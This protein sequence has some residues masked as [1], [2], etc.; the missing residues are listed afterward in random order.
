MKKT[1]GFPISDKK[2][3]KRRALVAKDIEKINNKSLIYIE[4]GYGKALGITDQE[5]VDMGANVVERHIVMKQDIICDPKIG[6]AG[7]LEDLTT[8][9]MIFGWVHAVQNKDITD[10]LINLK[11]SAIAWEDMFEN[12]RH[13]FWRNNEIAGEAAV[14]H[15]YNLYGKLPY[16]TKVAI[17]GRG[18]IG[19][20]AYKT[21]VALGADV[22]MYDRKTERL[23]REE[24]AE[25]D[26][27]VNAILWDVNRKD[28]II[29]K[30]DL[31]HM[32]KGAMIIDISCD[33][34]KGIETSIPTTIDNPVY[35]V[36]GVLH[37]VVDHTP[38][39]FYKTVSTTLSNE[40]C[41]YIDFI[42]E[43]KENPVL[44]NALI[45]ENGLIRDK[46]IVD[47][48]KRNPEKVL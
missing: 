6:D 40:I 46:R 19:R 9:Q 17:L 13:V 36:E 5:Y 47:F 18:N 32:K 21:L 20:G 1:I 23:F 35:E 28:H 29:Y 7:Y 30:E 41:K 25:Y 43:G 10:T 37:Y 12:G 27:L 48:Q 33:A 16:E 42:I 3:E 15:A 22:V 24:I 2:N 14:L 38:A 34:N 4:K 11:L 39:M 45:V 8:G 26:V 31:K 44:L